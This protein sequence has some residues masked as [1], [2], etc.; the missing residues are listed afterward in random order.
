M[1]DTQ[2]YLAIG[3]PILFNAAMLTLMVTLLRTYGA[4]NCAASKRYST[5]ASTT[6]KSGCSTSKTGNLALLTSQRS[7]A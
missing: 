3:V 1:A 7:S 5:P 2:L 6:S 4:P